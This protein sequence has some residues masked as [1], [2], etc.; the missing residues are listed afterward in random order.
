MYG[1]FLPESKP[2]KKPRKNR[3]NSESGKFRVSDHRIKERLQA[4]VTF[5][6]MHDKKNPVR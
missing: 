5:V 1:S 4:Y 6:W 3:E 2:R